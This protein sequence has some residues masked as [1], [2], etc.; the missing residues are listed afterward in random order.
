MQEDIDQTCNQ[1]VDTH[2]EWDRRVGATR[3][4]QLCN[5]RL[6]GV[7]RLAHRLL[8]VLLANVTSFA[9]LMMDAE[10]STFLQPSVCHKMSARAIFR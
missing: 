8:Y 6:V 4:H 1:S 9:S 7:F 5:H 3:S 2:N 10:L